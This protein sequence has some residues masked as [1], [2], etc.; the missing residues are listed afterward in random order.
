MVPGTPVPLFWCTLTAKTPE[1]PANGPQHC[2]A[3]AYELSDWQPGAACPECGSRVGPWRPVQGKALG[4]K[5]KLLMVGWPFG[6]AVLVGVSTGVV[7]SNYEA[8]P[9]PTWSHYLLIASCLSLPCALLAAVANTGITTFLMVRHAQRKKWAPP[10]RTT[11]Q[12]WIAVLIGLAASIAGGAAAL[13]LSLGACNITTV[14]R[15]AMW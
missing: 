12:I 5:N 2:A 15:S 7:G 11:T 10:E 8:G 4:G 1:T 13:G 9:D 3:C 14:P 6:L